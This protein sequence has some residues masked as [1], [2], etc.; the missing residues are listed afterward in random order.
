[1]GAAVTT[2]ELDYICDT[3][4]RPVA[5]GEGCLYLS[6][7]DLADH[8]RA[9]REWEASRDESGR[10]DILGLLGLPSFAA[11]R[12]HHDVCRPAGVDGYDITVEEIR[13]WRGLV[14][15]TAHLMEKNWLVET[16]WRVLLGNAANGRDRRIVELAHGDAA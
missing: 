2:V 13:T 1:M 6:F 16:D 9:K 15:W 12:I 3:C 5:D 4:L 14:K 11:W 7:G 8:R 10:L